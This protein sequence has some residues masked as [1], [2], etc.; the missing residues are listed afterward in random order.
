MQKTI[1]NKV[2]KITTQKT[3]NV[4]TIATNKQAHNYF[5]NTVLLNYTLYKNNNIV[6]RYTQT[7]HYNTI[8]KIA[9]NYLKLFNIL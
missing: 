1:N 3:N 9:L 6:Q 2:I 4:Q 5:K 7:A 8:A